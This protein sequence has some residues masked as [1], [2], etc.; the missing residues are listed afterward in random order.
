MA[1]A[2]RLPVRGTQAGARTQTCLSMFPCASHRPECRFRPD[3]GAR[4]L[5]AS[6]GHACCRS[7][8]RARKS[9]PSAPQ[10]FRSPLSCR[11]FRVV[12][13]GFDENSKV[14]H[15][16]VDNNHLVQLMWIGRKVYV[17]QAVRDD[18]LP[19]SGRLLKQVGLRAG[20]V[21]EEDEFDIERVLPESDNP[22][23]SA[24]GAIVIRIGLSGDW[25][26]A[27]A[28][29]VNARIRGA[30]HSSDTV[31]VA[32]IFRLVIRISSRNAS[33]SSIV[34]SVDR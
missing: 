29:V 10:I 21:V 18:G 22:D 5:P 6:S 13:T 30:V 12:N 17:L 32:A 26:N 28:I 23:I 15:D 20:E 1:R 34:P 11:R 33:V 3:A 8:R 14:V 31:W 24:D 27:G 16:I 19:A 7:L 2:G 4:S 25:I 9:S